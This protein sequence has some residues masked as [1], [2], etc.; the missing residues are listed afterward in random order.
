M[1]NLQDSFISYLAVVKGLSKNTLE[2]YG[3]DISKCVAYLEE[4]GVVDIREVD[5]KVILDFLT[6]LR[7]QNLNARSVARILVSI[8]QFFK[9]LLA[10]KIIEK[11][12]TFLIRPPKIRTSIPGV[13][14]LSGGEVVL[15]DWP[16]GPLDGTMAT[17]SLKGYAFEYMT[18]G[19]VVTLGDP[20]PWMCAGMTGGVVVSLLH[21]DLGLDQQAL[22]KR[23]APGAKVS[24]RPP[25]DALWN[26]VTALLRDYALLLDGAGERRDAERV[27][28]VLGQRER[29]VAII[30]QH[31]Q[32]D[33]RIST[34]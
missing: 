12:P 4:R 6:H 18:G 15:G 29:F 21:P 10:E 25:D 34:E 26:Q 22:K 32:A 9:F 28:S 20:G 3:R 14:S 23:L 2:S 11:D 33:P 17:A 1:N 13:L 24:F 19:L 27:R 5:Y 8:K 30:P 7:E 31:A 16:E